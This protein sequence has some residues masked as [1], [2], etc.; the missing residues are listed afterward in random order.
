[1][2]TETKGITVKIDAGLHAQVREYVESHGL[3]MA[4]FVSQA[5]DNELHP[6]YFQQEETTMTNNRTIAFQVPE[7]LY[8][9]IKDYLTRYNMTQKQFFLGLVETELERDQE[10]RERLQTE[11]QR[12]RDEAAEEAEGLEAEPAVP[13]EADRS[14]ARGEEPGCVPEQSGE[15]GHDGPEEADEAVHDGPEQYDAPD[16]DGAGQDEDYDRDG[17]EQGFGL[18][19]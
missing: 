13:D 15:A 1:M 3:T 9:R 8:R 17:E 19:M 11:A 6:K 7:E 14:Q 18:T 16:R 4:Q 2:T 5:L 12:D 10:E